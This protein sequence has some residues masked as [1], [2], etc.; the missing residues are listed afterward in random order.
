MLVNRSNSRMVLSNHSVC[1]ISLNNFD[2][3]GGKYVVGVEHNDVSCSQSEPI[4]EM[5]N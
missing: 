1:Y 4:R 2:D 5:E 3:V